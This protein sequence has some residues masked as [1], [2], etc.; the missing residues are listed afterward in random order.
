MGLLAAREAC[1]YADVVGVELKRQSPQGKA[2]PGQA[3]GPAEVL[4]N[5][6]MQALLLDLV[7]R[8]HGLEQL[9]PIACRRCAPRPVHLWGSS[10]R[11]SRSQASSFMDE[12]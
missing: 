10:S 6:D 12:I 8:L 3:L 5:Q 9:G 11:H 1:G 2:A 4:A 7:H